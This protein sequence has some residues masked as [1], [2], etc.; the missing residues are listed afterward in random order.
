MFL[1]KGTV[2]TEPRYLSEANVLEQAPGKPKSTAQAQGSLARL[3]KRLKLNE[4]QTEC[5]L[6]VIPRM[7]PHETSHYEWKYHGNH[8]FFG[9]VQGNQ[10]GNNTCKFTKL[11]PLA[12]LF[13][14]AALP[15]I[16]LDLNKNA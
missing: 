10:H 4:L 8:L 15:L 6:A 1:L 7:V 14:K 9:D 2:N 13:A 3:V 11:L 16:P 12:K 5:V